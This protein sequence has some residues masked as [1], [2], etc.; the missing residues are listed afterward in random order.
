MASAPSVATYSYLP[1]TDLISGMTNSAGFHWS[2]AY[3]PQRDLIASVENV[4][5][6]ETVS[7]F[8]YLNNAIAMRTRRVDTLGGSALPVTNAFA[9]NMRGELTAATMGTNS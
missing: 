5:N 6:A 7:R 4:F 9:N 2:R 8:D 3:E 1:G